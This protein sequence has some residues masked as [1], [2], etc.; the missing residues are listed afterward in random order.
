VP[1]VCQVYKEALIKSGESECRADFRRIKAQKCRNTLCISS[2]CNAEPGGNLPAGAEVGLI[3]A[4]LE[5]YKI[6][7]EIADILRFL[8]LFVN[9]D[10]Y[11][12][13]LPRAA[14]PT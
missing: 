9:Y 3:S 1:V 13:G 5:I 14:A 12:A 7:G 8:P 2:F 6:V 4:S 11:Y 10:L